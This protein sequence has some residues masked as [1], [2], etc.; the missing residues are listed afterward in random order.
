MTRT[1][2][3]MTEYDT[4]RHQEPDSTLKD[5]NSTKKNTTNLQI[6]VRSFCSKKYNFTRFE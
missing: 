2:D 3:D 1:S 5:I 4:I 6:N